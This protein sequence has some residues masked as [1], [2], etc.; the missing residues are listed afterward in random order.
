MEIKT[1]IGFS[2][3][4][5][6]MYQEEVIKILGKP[7][8]INKEEL[9]NHIVY[10]YNDRMI[11]LK[12]DEEEYYKLVSIDVY[13]AEI[14]M[15]NQNIFSQSKEEIISFLKNNGHENTKYEEYDTFETL[16]CKEI[17]TTFEFEFGKL[18]GVEF[19][20]LYDN[21][22]NKIIWPEKF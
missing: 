4:I 2:N 19:S 5:F 22:G 21:A 9:I 14:I 16:F 12:F 13:S 18:R 3:I 8:K 10:Y 20:P 1:G 6:G 7:N 15:Y 11:K 17:W